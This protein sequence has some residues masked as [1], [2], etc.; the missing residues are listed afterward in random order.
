MRV[1]CC[2][3]FYYFLFKFCRWCGGGSS[4]V[5]MF[6]YFFLSFSVNHLSAIMM[7]FRNYT[8]ISSCHTNL[9]SLPLSV[10]HIT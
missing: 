1:I 3:G 10:P 7:F 6:I 5:F 9:Y 8:F 2:V 4:V